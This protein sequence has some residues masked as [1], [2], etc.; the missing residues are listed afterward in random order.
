MMIRLKWLKR[1]FQENTVADSRVFGA[2]DETKPKMQNV[3]QNKCSYKGRRRQQ[4]ASN[5]AR[6]ESGVDTISAWQ[7]NVSARRGGGGDGSHRAEN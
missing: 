6:G 4:Q 2:N 7:C 3:P 1:L 5:M